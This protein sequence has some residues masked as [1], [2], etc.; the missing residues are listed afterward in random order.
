MAAMAVKYERMGGRPTVQGAWRGV[1]PF[2]VC[3]SVRVCVAGVGGREVKREIECFFTSTP[4]PFT[5]RYF[6]HG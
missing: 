3:V 2:M 1:Q 6:K 5:E 4:P